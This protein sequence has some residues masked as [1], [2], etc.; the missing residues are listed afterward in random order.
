VLYT[1]F[2]REGKGRGWIG[3]FNAGFRRAAPVAGKRNQIVI[4]HKRILNHRAK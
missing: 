4:R 1:A 3:G 2:W